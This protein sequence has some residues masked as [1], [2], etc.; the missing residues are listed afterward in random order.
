MISAI[1][2]ARHSSTRL[3]G[4]VL[5]PILGRPMLE[6]QI[7]RVRRARCIDM[8]TVATSSQTDDDPVAGLCG[9][10]GVRCHRG[11]LED[12]LDRMYGAA[13]PDAPSHVVRLTGDCPLADPELIEQVVGFCIEG[14][15]DYASNT[16]EPTFPDGLD[17][18]MMRLESL[19][20]AWREA[21]LS[22]EREH[23]TPF[24]YK[25]PE[26]FRLGS[27]KAA[28]DL[29]YLRWTVDEPEDFE[30]I[31]RIYR[32]LYPK[33]PAFS[34]SDI[35]RLLDASPELKICNTRH[36]RNEGYLKSTARD[37]E[38]APLPGV[39]R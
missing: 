1:I 14:G 4:K 24:L 20:T 33:N 26:R 28:Q 17:V 32:E 35:L 25:H 8:L 15:Y 22:S 18:E 36:R 39:T 19:A 27:F 9:A 6:R 7:E 37:A 2:Q 3:P 38:S 29:S 13:L 16:L 30:L 31:E 12:V 34:T 23:V 10:L 11:S 5:K 21:R